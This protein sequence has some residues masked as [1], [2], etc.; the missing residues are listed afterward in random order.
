MLL[1]ITFTLGLLCGGVYL[2]FT[3]GLLK[4]A[5]AFPGMQIPVNSEQKKRSQSL[6]GA[7]SRAWRRDAIEFFRLG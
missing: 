7:L 6:N 1:P 4:A 2:C 5:C 3:P